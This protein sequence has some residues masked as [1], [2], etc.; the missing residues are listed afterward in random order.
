MKNAPIETES[1]TPRSI[2]NEDR[3]RFRLL[4]M[5]YDTFLCDDARSEG[6]FAANRPQTV[7]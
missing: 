3:F 1:R 4:F 2:V 6:F 7:R 5:N